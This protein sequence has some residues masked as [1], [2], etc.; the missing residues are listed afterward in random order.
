MITT[1]TVWQVTLHVRLRSI[2]VRDACWQDLCRL[3]NGEPALWM[4]DLHQ[5]L[6][7]LGLELIDQILESF[8][9]AFLQVAHSH[10]HSQSFFLQLVQILV[11]IALITYL[12]ITY[13]YFAYCSNQA[14]LS[15]DS[16]LIRVL[17]LSLICKKCLWENTVLRNVL[18]YYVFG[19]RACR[20]RS[21]CACSRTR[22]R[23]CW[24]AR[25]RRSARSAGSS[26][27]ARCRPSRASCTGPRSSSGCARGPARS[28]P[29]TSSTST[30]PCL[31]R[32]RRARP[33]RPARRVRV[34]RARP[35]RV[36]AA[37]QAAQLA[38]GGRRHRRAQCFVIRGRAARRRRPR[39]LCGRRRAGA[40][41]ERWQL[42]AQHS[43]RATRA[44][45]HA[46]SAAQ[47]R[48]APRMPL[49]PHY[50]LRTRAH[51]MCYLR[52]ALWFVLLSS[53]STYF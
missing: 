32:R 49:A 52:K 10:S 22:C 50:L 1:R 13:G 45:H 36:P 39:L 28:W 26:S 40:A 6:R 37:G 34:R 12:I 19:G 31:R 11:R 46:C 25:S 30:P 21:W 51:P 23:C 35:T 8:K 20:C 33:R 42:R 2:D 38:L 44:P 14:S 53:T 43:N 29:T 9:P 16:S 27:G 41:G 5:M 47:L 48:R 3:V 4:T 17:Y 15:R 24:R 18:K 7:T